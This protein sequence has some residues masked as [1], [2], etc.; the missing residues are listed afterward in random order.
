MKKKKTLVSFQN[1]FL[2]FGYDYQKIVIDLLL[3]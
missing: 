2:K 3:E 1:K